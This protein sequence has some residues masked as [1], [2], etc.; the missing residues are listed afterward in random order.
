MKIEDVLSGAVV[1]QSGDT[2]V[3]AFSQRLT[4]TDAD[5]AA[6]MISEALPESIK[7]LVIDGVQALAVIRGEAS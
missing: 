4:M 7:V 2:L 6:A 5:Q 1:V 3:V